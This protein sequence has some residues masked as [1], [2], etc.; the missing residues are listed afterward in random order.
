MKEKYVP[1]VGHFVLGPRDNW[2]IIDEIDEDG[3]CWLIGDDGEDADA[4]P[5]DLEWRGETV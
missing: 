4:D 2:W 5:E 1:Q 3:H